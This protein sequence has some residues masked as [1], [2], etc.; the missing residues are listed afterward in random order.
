[1]DSTRYNHRSISLGLAAATLLVAPLAMLSPLATASPATPSVAVT[2]VNAQETGVAQKGRVDAQRVTARQFSQPPRPTKAQRADLRADGPMAAPRTTVA[3]TTPTAAMGPG[4]AAPAAKQ[5]VSTLLP[6]DFRLFRNQ[7]LPAGGS[8]SA[9]D[10][11]S[12]TEAG[13]HIMA[14]GNWYS[15]YSHDRGATYTYLNPFSIFGSGFCC[16]QVVAYDMSHDRQF[17]LLQYN[18]RLV[19]ANSRPSNLATWCSYVLTPQMMGQA[20]GLTFDYNKIAVSTNNV[21]VTSNV[22]NGGG[23]FVTNIVF[24]LPIDAMSRCVST[25]FQYVARNTEFS[26]AFAQGAGDV[27]Y[28][29]TNWPTNVAMGSTFRILRW[30]DSSGSY[31]AYDRAIA[32]F[33]PL[34]INQGNCG[35]ADAVVLNWCQRSDSR[36][37]GHGYLAAAGAKNN[38]D[39]ILGWAFNAKQDGSHPF[40]YIRRVYFRTTGLAYVGS[41]EFFGTWAAHLY[42]TMAADS[43]GHVGMAFAWG[44]G[45][46]TN[47]YYPGSGVL[48]D[49]DISPNQPWAYSFYQTGLGNPC[50]NSDGTRRWGDYL[51][52]H[53]TYPSA[54]GFQATGFSL[55]SNAGSCGSAANVLV[56]N[57][58]YGRQRDI[59]GYQRYR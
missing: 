50:L 43:R 56:A 28:W 25:G 20:A 30:A 59:L 44:G 33:T 4:T 10:E 53:P 58:T 46:G 57:V 54:V 36:M 34:F 22:Y 32:A 41:S 40:P 3:D 29:G 15:A 17:W 7:R 27:M 26:P 16:D 9:V 6:T 14:V 37:S 24:R 52:I 19:L 12:S 47:H 49:D 39:A 11:P 5:A 1:M 2:T 51:D 45:T 18:N 38:D 42:P 35:S 23:S 55:G 31:T 8:R 21:Y 48:L 13:N